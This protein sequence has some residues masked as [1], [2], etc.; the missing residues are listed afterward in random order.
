ML[1]DPRPRIG[2]WSFAVPRWL[3]EALRGG[4]LG[5]GYRGKV[6]RLSDKGYSPTRTREK[7]QS[8]CFESVSLPPSWRHVGPRWCLL[9]IDSQR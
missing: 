7:I 6:R 3:S 5:F 1:E 8:R 9:P 4:C 2:A